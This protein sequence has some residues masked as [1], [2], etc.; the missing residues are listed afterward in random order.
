MFTTNKETKETKKQWI[1]SA[2]L[3][4]YSNKYMHGSTPNPD[5]NC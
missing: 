5:P 3:A 2:L 4:Y 1:H